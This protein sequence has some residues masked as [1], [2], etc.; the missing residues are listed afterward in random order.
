M[1]EIVRRVLAAICFSV[2][3]CTACAFA[4]EDVG[5][6]PKGASVNTGSEA[7]PAEHAEPKPTTSIFPKAGAPNPQPFTLTDRFFDAAR[8]GDLVAVKLCVE[9]GVDPKAKDEVGRSALAYAVRDGHS[10]DVVQ[11]LGDH[12]VAADDPDAMG[13]SPLHEAAGA[14]DTAIVKWLLAR[15]ANVER[16]DMQGRTPL[17]TAVLGGSR[18]I[19]ALLIAAGADP[20]IPDHFGDTPLIQ[21]CNKGLDEIAK[22]LVDKGAD[23]SAKDQEGRT[24]AQRAEENATYCRGLAAPKPAS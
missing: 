1:H 10:L 18:E 24:A 5:A 21:A 11:F 20:N 19:A 15:G 17:Q 3:V 14:G 9:K 12:G 2:L 13:R 23:P 7:V 6:N 8:R 16:K 22:L 4:D